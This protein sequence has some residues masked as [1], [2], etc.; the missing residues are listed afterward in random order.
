MM[1]LTPRFT[2]S[3]AIVPG[4]PPMSMHDEAVQ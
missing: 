2:N 3:L 4:A 1:V